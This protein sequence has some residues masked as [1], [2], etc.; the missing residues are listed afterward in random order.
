MKDPCDDALEKKIDASVGVVNE[1]V[2]IAVDAVNEHA[3]TS[4]EKLAREV[5]VA[6]DK[7][8]TL[9]LTVATALKTIEDDRARGAT[10]ERTD[11]AEMLK[12]HAEQKSRD[13]RE[14]GERSF[15]M[16][17]D[18]FDALDLKVESVEKKLTNHITDDN[19]VAKIVARHATYWGLFIASLPI[20]IGSI[21]AWLKLK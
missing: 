6:A 16:I 4:A 11:I 18:R 1:K 9:T 17:M 14:D 3:D 8:A 15:G 12:E 5:K 19:V 20:T 13:Q 10:R 7:L 21:L 2:T